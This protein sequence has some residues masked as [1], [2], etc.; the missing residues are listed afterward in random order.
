LRVGPQWRVK[1]VII[2]EGIN[3]GCAAC[4]HIGAGAV[5]IGDGFIVVKSGI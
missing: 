2:S 1:Y 3:E 5:Q 4:L